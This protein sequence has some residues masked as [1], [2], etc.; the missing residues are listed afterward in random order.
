[1]AE[2]YSDEI[3]PRFNR[4]MKDVIAAN[5]TRTSFAPW[6]VEL[7]LDFEACAAERRARR[8]LMQRYHRA[9]LRQLQNRR[10]MPMKL[11]TYIGMLQE[12]QT[13]RD[14]ARFLCEQDDG[15]E[16]EIPAP[17]LS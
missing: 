2:E 9:V 15:Q 17:A 13:S 4:L 5:W 6:E 3:L 10:E 1:M 8:D 12:R 7:I 16:K 14:Q 11:S